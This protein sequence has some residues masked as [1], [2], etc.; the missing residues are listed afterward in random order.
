MRITRNE[1]KEMGMYTVY[2]SARSV[3]NHYD[4]KGRIKWQKAFRAIDYNLPNR[5]AAYDEMRAMEQYQTHL[6]EVRKVK[7]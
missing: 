6:L 5:R 3:F 7:A 1:N 2:F 4:P